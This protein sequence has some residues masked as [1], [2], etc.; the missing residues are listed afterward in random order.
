MS[1]TMFNHFLDV[2]IALLDQ[3]WDAGYTFDEVNWPDD[4]G[5]KHNQF[6]SLRTYRTLL[7]PVHERAVA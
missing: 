6:F 3:V 7:K 2:N 1:V 5:Y 4:M